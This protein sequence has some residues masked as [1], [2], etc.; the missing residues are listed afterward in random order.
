[1]HRLLPL[2]VFFALSNS[3][4]ADNQQLLDELDATISLREQFIQSKEK[5]ISLLKNKLHSETDSV[6]ML[7]TLNDLYNEYYVFR[8]DSAMAIAHQ[9]LLLAERQGNHEYTVLFRI[10]LAE[11]L[12]IGSLYAEAVNT[13]ES[14][15]PADVDDKYLFKYYYLFF[16]TYSYWSD[17]CHDQTFAPRYRQK[18]NDYLKQAMQYAN[19]ND[20]YY[21]YYKGEQNVF[22]DPDPKAAREYYH[23]ALNTI[24]E[25]SRVYAMAAF[26]LAGNYKV[27]G[28]LEKYEEFLIKA[29]LSDLKCCT[30]EN[31][32]LQT[33]ALL[34][35]QKGDDYL[36]RAE[37][38][39]Y[40]SMEDAKFY[41]NRL[42]MLEISRIMPQIMASYQAVVKKQ[43]NILRYAISFISLLVVGLLCTSF[44]IHRQNKKLAA[45][46]KAL[47]ENN[48]QLVTLNQQLAVSNQHQAELNG[49]LEELNA[50]LV[51]TNK[52][53]EGLASIYIDL[54]A[55]YIDKLKKY[56]T[57]VK[58]KIKAN[59]AQELL[60]TISSTRISEEDAATFLNRFDKA[61]LELYPTF[62]EEFNALLT[63]EARIHP[64]SPVALTTELRTFALIRLGVKNTADIAGLMFLSVQTIYNCR[65]VIKNKAIN[66]E[67]FDD[68]IL[69]LCTVI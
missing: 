57:L 41:N 61:F 42:R 6:A 39:I 29:S 58:R 43:N 7:I 62:T 26:A 16:S 30:M 38:Y 18:S 50:K 34:L 1:M 40:T 65:S 17:Y 23:H 4:F 9:G 53:R 22:V 25:E 60:Q 3:M 19:T 49:Q 66:K 15:S 45:R 35:F 8:F 36:K 33:L 69:K 46:R 37:R 63:E 59:Q 20:P 13:L 64:K 11:I 52:R 67:T 21:T 10:H 47:A 12:A 48:E 28:D 56:Q 55:K 31:M 68:D 32:A 14:V 54:C 2:F 44:Y 27:A 5:K 24:P 51:G